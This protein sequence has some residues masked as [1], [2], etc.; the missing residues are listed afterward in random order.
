M[1]E[2]LLYMDIDTMVVG[3]LMHIFHYYYPIM[4]RTDKYLAAV[5]ESLSPP[6][7][8]PPMYGNPDIK[9]PFNAG[10]LLVRPNVR[11]FEQLVQLAQNMGGVFWAEQAVLNTQYIDANSS[12]VDLPFAYNADNCEAI[13]NNTR[14]ALEKKIIIHFTCVKP[15]EEGFGYWNSV[16]PYVKLWNTLP[17]FVA[18]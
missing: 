9:R 5:V 18:P 11:H 10:V 8:H 15:W 13:C 17:P 3:D 4:V 16:L 6:K 14:W 12:R 1:F 7:C 2:S